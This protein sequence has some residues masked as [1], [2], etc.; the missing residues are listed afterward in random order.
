MEYKIRSAII[1]DLPLL[2]RLFFNTVT[3][4]SMKFY[5][6]AEKKIW[7]RNAWNKPHW[8]KKFRENDFYIATLNFEVIGFASLNKEGYIDTIYVAVPYQRQGVAKSLY[9]TLESVAIERGI[10]VLTSDVSYLAKAFFEKNGFVVLKKN[11]HP[12]EGE[13]LVN[14]SVQKVIADAK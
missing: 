7:A 2:Q 11:E 5:T 9:K 14:F 6:M 1:S 13:V 3:N 4:G 8:E 10:S 12:I